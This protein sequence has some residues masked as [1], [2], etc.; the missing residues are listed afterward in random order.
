[1]SHFKLDRAFVIPMIMVILFDQSSKFVAQQKGIVIYNTGVSL[2]LFTLVPRM[3]LTVAL[4]ALLIGVALIF[5]S[6]WQQIPLASG[7]FFGGGISN[8]LDRLIAGGVRD[9]L[10]IPL[11]TIHNN[12]ADYAIGLGLVT[13]IFLTL[14]QTYVIETTKD[15]SASHQEMADL[16]DEDP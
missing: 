8:L 2:G 1:M 16:E 3:F 7:L 13:M 12:L 9:W 6:I 11:M 5:R 4:L 14:R 15:T 10:P